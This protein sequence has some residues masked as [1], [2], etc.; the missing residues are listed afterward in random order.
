MICRREKIAA[1]R[2]QLIPS[3]MS[4]DHRRKPMAPRGGPLY[5]GKAD[6]RG[7]PRLSG[8]C[9]PQRPNRT[10]TNGPKL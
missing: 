1:E 6:V 10:Y 5:V 8:A 2:E 9:H 3:A 4:D 7:F